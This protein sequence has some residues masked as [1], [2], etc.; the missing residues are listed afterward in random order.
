MKRLILTTLCCLIFWFAIYPAAHLRAADAVSIFDGKTLAGWE[1]D[2][3]ETWR[4]ENGEIVGGSLKRKQQHND[5]LAT[6][7]EYENF[8]LRLKIKLLGT[9]GFVNSGVQFR[10]KRVPNNFEVSG[11]QADFGAGTDG[12]LYDESRRNKNMA[13]APKE[14]V[15][16]TSKKGEW[17]DYRIRADGSHIQLWLNGVQTVD[18]T[19]TDE[20]IAKS[21]ILALQIHGGAVAEV[22]FK[23]LQIEELPPS[24]KEEPKKANAPAPPPPPPLKNGHTL[25]DGKSLKGWSTHWPEMWR[26]EAGG[27]GAEGAIVGGDIN[28]VLSHSDYLIADGDAENFDLRFKFKLEGTKYLNTGMYFRSKRLAPTQML[29]YQADIGDTYF[30]GIYDDG[31]NRGV[32]QRPAAELQ[33]KAYK[34]GEWNDYRVLAEGRRIRTWINGYAMSDYIEK[35]KT[36]ARSGAIGIEMSKGMKGLIR[37]KDIEIEELPPSNEPEDETGNDPAS[38]IADKIKPAPKLAPYTIGKFEI[39]PNEVIVF[40]GPENMVAEQR[41]GWIETALTLFGSD[42]KPRFRHMGWEGDTVYRQNRMENYGTWKSNLDAVDATAVVAWFGQIE[43]FEEKPAAEF[44]AAYAKLLDE[45]AKRTP[46]IVILSP[47]AFARPVFHPLAPDNRPRNALVAQYAQA[48]RELAEERGYAYIDLVGSVDRK[49]NTRDGFHFDSTF[50]VAVEIYKQLA[51]GDTAK[52]Q[53][54]LMILAKRLRSEIVEKNRLWFDAWRCSNWAFAYGDRTTQPFATASDKFPA[55]VDDLKRYRPLI[56]NADARIYAVLLEN[57]PPAR[58]DPEPAIAAP[59]AKSPDEEMKSFTLYPGFSISLFADESQGIVKPIQMR[60]DER[61]RLWVLCAPSYPQLQPGKI[62]NDYL[63]M[64]EDTSGSGKA[65]KVTRVIEGLNMP[66]GFEFGTGGARAGGGVYVCESTQLTHYKFDADGKPGGRE[67][68]LSGFGTGDSHQMINSLRWCPDGHLWFTQGYHIWSYVETPYGVS[69]LNRSGL[70]RFNPRTLKL[71]GFFNDSTAGLNSWGVT[72][73]DYGQVFHGGGANNCL[74]YSTPGLIPTLH[75]LKYREDFCVSRGKSMEPEF[76]ESRHLPDELQGVLLKSTYFTSQVSMY[77]IHDD[78][79]G[80]KSEPLPDLI[81]SK[82]NDFRPLETRAGPDGAIY[83]CDWLNPIIGH[84]QASY[85]DPRRDKTHGRIWRMTADGRPLVQ[86]P[87]LEKMNAAELCEQLKSPERWTRD[88]AR[89]LL[90]AKPKAEAIAATDGLLNI[91]DGNE[92]RLLYEIS[93]VYLA[94]EEPRPELANRLLHSTDFRLRCWGVRLIGCWHNSLPK[95]IDWLTR[96]ASDEH[97]RVRMEACVAASYLNSFDALKAATLVLDKPRDFSIDYALTQCIFAL[98]QPFEKVL[99]E[100]NAGFDDRTHALIHVL[101][102]LGGKENATAIM[103]LIDAGKAAGK[104][105]ED[106]LIALAESAGA[107]ELKYALEKGASSARVLNALVETVRLRKIKPAGDLNAP[108]EILLATQ[109]SELRAAALRL[110]GAWQIKALAERANSAA[111]NANAPAAERAA[112]VFALASLNGKTAAPALLNLTR[113][114]AAPVRIAAIESLAPL[115]LNDAAPRAAELLSAVKS[116]DEAGPLLKPFMPLNGGAQALAKQIAEKKLPPDSA[117][118]ALQWLAKTGHDDPALLAALNA[119]AGIAAQTREYSAE[120][121]TKLVADAKTIGDKTRGEKLFKS[122]ELSCLKCHKVGTEGASVGPELTSVARGLSQELIVEGVLWPKRQVKEGY[123]L[124][125][126]AL[127][128][129]TRHQGFKHAETATTLTLRSTDD[130]SLKSF[131]KSEIKKRNDAG[132]I[133][134]DG[135]VDRLT[136][137]QLSDLLKYLMTLG[138]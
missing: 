67:V 124:T 83:I 32:L 61:G 53:G 27:A 122:A 58:P 43:A 130:N 91:I 111:L 37:F 41:S 8:E 84:Y 89:R 47:T 79:A 17:N 95:S 14:I 12:N 129:G 106:L 87:P 82:S 103:K 29:G 69:E 49:I 110:A 16:K 107:D 81:A 131:D 25:F 48:A 138:Q 93:G 76:L 105:R 34:K 86:R 115:N 64:L 73:D 13:L 99:A 1:G 35:D 96:A 68:V 134:P 114:N 18:Y 57:E 40:A 125:Q 33:A 38:R 4:V 72:F 15:E 3:K 112:A 36:V 66:M 126:L 6:I 70:W 9:E 136:Q 90:Y 80:F 31:R 100:G 50:D 116:A 56:A 78:G 19:E 23:D 20:K 30:G 94:H 21:G 63:L 28:Q 137:K 74:Y 104:A 121:V 118:A 39:A 7:K 117:N 108:V 132:T 45:F 52:A 11:F 123:L 98:A 5:F 26:I 101:N 85:R 120:L 109:D 59:D 44:K 55:F 102:T 92:N 65:D 62:A 46:R 135:L 60:W 71:D 97:P 54:Q 127:K 10:S 2:T 133:M 128:D 42:K 75:P 119:A 77:R 88:Q 51:G 113:D 22:H 24:P